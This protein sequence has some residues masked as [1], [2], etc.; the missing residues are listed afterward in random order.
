MAAATASEGSVNYATA[1]FADNYVNPRGIPRV[2]FV[3]NVAEYVT[4]RGVSVDTI[5]RQFQEQHSKY[6]LM[7][8]KLTQNKSSLS[9]KIPEIT[10]TI[11]TVRYL[12][13][14]L[15]MEK[16]DLATHFGLTETVFCEAKLKP[17]STVHLWL[18]ANVMVEY[19]FDEALALLDKNMAAA[20]KNLDSTV[21][22][23]AWLKDQQVVIEV[24]TSRVYNYDVIRRRKEK[25]A[26]K[27]N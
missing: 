4:K 5:L 10:K 7:E 15:Q 20:T 2:E 27:S 23:L 1:Q 8:H 14:K 3:E 21:E 24:N 16:T 13:Q 6:K 9:G 22:D 26:E 17:Q 18:G 19:S 11:E 25:E 12:K